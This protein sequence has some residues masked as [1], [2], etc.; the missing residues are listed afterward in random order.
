MKRVMALGATLAL[1][2]AP[3]LVRLLKAQSPPQGSATHFAVSPPA[4]ANV[5]F[6][7]NFSVSTL[8]QSNSAAKSYMGAV[9]FTSTDPQAVLPPD[10]TFTTGDSG[11]HMFSA[12]LNMPGTQT[13]TATDTASSAITG[14]SNSITVSATPPPPPPTFAL[15]DLGPL[16][17]SA[18]PSGAT[19]FNA[20]GQVTGFRFE[21][22]ASLICSAGGANRAFLWNNGAYTELGTLGGAASFGY[23][24]NNSGQIAGSADVCGNGAGARAFLWQNGVMTALDPS[25]NPGDYSS[26]FAINTNGDVAG[27]INHAN[28]GVG[29]QPVVWKGGTA[30]GLTVLASLGCQFAPNCQ[31]EARAI[32]DAGQAAGWGYGPL[33]GGY[34]HAVRWDSNGQPTDLVSLGANY[35]DQANAINSKGDVAGYSQLDPN[36]YYSIVRA[37]FW[38]NGNPQNPQDLGTIPGFDPL[39]GSANVTDN[40]SS[41]WGINSKG[42][43]VGISAGSANAVLYGNGGR[44]FLYIPKPAPAAGGTIYDLLS[45]LAPGTN[46]LQLMAAWAINDNGQI[47]GVGF[48]S[49]HNQHGFLLTPIITPTTTALSSSVNPSV[50]GQQVSFTATVTP[51]QSSSLTPTGIVTLSDGSTVLGTA[52]LSSGT[53]IFNSSSLSVGTHT[54]T[55]SY[56]GDNNFGSSTSAAVTQIVNQTGTTTTLA[57]S[58]NPA[59]FGQTVTLTATITPVAPGAGTA[60]GTVAFLDGATTLGTVTLNSAAT[61]TFTSSSL[62]PGSHNITASY[63]GDPN[64]TA[65]ASAATSFSVGLTAPTIASPASGF[66]TTNSSVTVTGT[67]TT[68]ALVAI[69]DGTTTVASS[70]VDPTGNFSISITLAIGAHSLTAKQTLGAAT[71]VASAA[72]SVTVA[73]PAPT[74]TSP[75]SGFSTTN[76]SVIVTGLGLPNASVNV[77]DGATTVG[78]GTVNRAGSFAVTTALPVGTHSLTATQTLNGVASASSASV[79]VIV[80]LPPVQITD[81]ETIRVSDAASFPDVFDAETVKVTDQVT[82]HAFFPITISPAPP[83]LSAVQNRAYSGATFSATGGYQGLTLSESGAIPGMSFAISGASAS[84]SGTPTQAGTFPFTITATDSIGNVLNQSY[85]LVV[86]AACPAISVSP[87]GSL[88]IVTAGSPFSQAFNATGGV[89]ATAWSQSGV[90]PT[91]MSFSAGVLSGTPTQPGTF[92]MTIVASDQNGCQ[93]SSNVS[94]LVVPPPAVIVDNETIRVTDTSSFPDVFDPETV[95]VADAVWVTPLIQ[96]AAP[97]VDYSAGSLGFGNVVAGQTGTQSLTVSDIGQA[98]LTLSSAAV[99]PGSAFAI[100]QISCSNGTTSLPTTLPV[101]GACAFLISYLAPSSGTASNDTLTFTDNAALSNVASIPAG[102]NYAQS[103]LLNGSGTTTPPPPPPPAVIPITDN[104]TIHVTDA[105]S[106]PDVFDPEKITVTD[107]VSVQVFDATTTSISITG[108]AVYGTPITVAVSVSSSTATV[109]GNVT[110]SLDGGAASTMALTSG[111]ATFNL[112]ILSVRPHLLAANFPPQGNFLGS[113]AVTKFAVT[114]AT[115]VISWKNPAPITYGTPLGSA[116]LSAIASVQGNFVYSP[117][118]GTVLTAGNQTL[119]VTFTPKDTTDYTTASASVTL[120][121]NQATPTITWGNPAPVLYGTALSGTQLNATATVSGSFAYTPALGTVLSAGTQTLSVSFTPAD[122]ID[123]TTATAS[124]MLVVNNTPTGLGATVLPVDPSTGTS[125]VSLTFSNVT[126]AG[127]TSLAI[128]KSGPATPAGFA[129]GT[130]PIYFNLSTTAGYKPP[131]TVCIK[132]AGISFPNNTPA[133]F[134]YENGAWVN[135]MTSVDTIHMIVCGNVTALSPFALFAPLPVL[136]ITANSVARQYGQANPAFAVS[137]NGFVN[138][139]T[140]SMLSG[141]LSC[142][143]PATSASAIGAYPI[144]CSGLTSSN[145]IIKFAPGVLTITPAPLT[146]TAANV[147]RVYGAAN[148]VFTGTITGIQNADNITATYAT[149][150]TPASPVGMYAIVPTLVDPGGKL[151]NYAVTLNKG[152][153]TVIQASTT[154]ALSVTPN[155]SNFGQSVTLTATV[156]PVAP[157]AGT[158]TGKVTFL[159]GSATLGTGTLS[160]A[161]VATFTTSSLAAGNHSLSASYSGDSNFSGSSSSTVGDQVLCGVLISLSPSTVPVGGT[162]TVTGKVISCS[163]ITQIVVVK[164]TLSGPSQPNSCSSTKSVM[165][166]TPPFPLP[167]KT[168][169]TISFPFKV[170]SSGVCPG[171]YSITATT[172]INGVAVDT[173]TASLTITAH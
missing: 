70:L 123:Y 169:Q 60:T 44:A 140:A 113:S 56:A 154:T 73:P 164:F 35:A 122:S 59:N 92:P 125:P 141:T 138:G 53:A 32:N 75:A 137:Y 115:P 16:N 25:T 95:K 55:A 144:A 9:H 37:V 94:L 173:S 88:G 108:G 48:D 36:V 68:G 78:T 69:L 85:S 134:H 57:A 46:W 152:T 131:I 54:I 93:G 109:T 29:Y 126:Q 47:V 106:F 99:S 19:A 41:A 71:S 22:F 18:A 1:L 149:A 118:A 104:E 2:L 66:S 74:I 105:P 161:A 128:S 65:S 87:S 135:V 3:L 127:V 63:G 42:Q 172:L 153:L 86:V 114:Q 119:S 112:G 100:S 13:I 39:Y 76:P 26:A 51:N 132:Y 170:P 62:G 97:V 107:Q 61:A 79:T 167:P 91:G 165:F 10:Y 11:T 31:G 34:L 159:D 14:T 98:P 5:G 148:P 155:P 150:A 67:G 45:L 160:S 151:G 89:G 81:N 49:N 90:L 96:V 24:I 80:Q 23:A 156:A 21:N 82:V 77:L 145:Y 33:V 147:Q 84:F 50:F 43:I 20:S 52:A 168:S 103:I 124:V 4:L 117:T 121:V 17:V 162:I 142:V 129:V 83:I 139:D 130:P 15:T 157:G 72:V 120:V 158:G 146:I 8:D 30:A 116:Q 58:P 7:F 133:L 111:S 163:T 28:T 101:G 12:T 102:S 40:Q 136:T 27:Y 171:T 38:Q 143:S 110:L 166:T 6:V 64:F